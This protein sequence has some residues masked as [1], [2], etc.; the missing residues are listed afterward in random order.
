MRTG[1]LT[2]T[3]TIRVTLCGSPKYLLNFSKKSILGC[4][5]KDQIIWLLLDKFKLEHSSI[6]GLLVLAE[7]FLA[8]IKSFPFTFDFLWSSWFLYNELHIRGSTGGCFVCTDTVG[9]ACAYLSQSFER[10]RHRNPLAPP[11]LS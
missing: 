5:C 9:D 3:S 2:G 11:R 10:A 7:R 8:K 4:R 6:S 1:V